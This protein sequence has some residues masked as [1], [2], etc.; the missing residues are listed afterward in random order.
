MSLDDDVSL[1]TGYGLGI[2]GTVKADSHIA[3]C[4]RA[5]P[6]LC[7]CHAPRVLCPL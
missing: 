1:V 5:V 4:A 6:M 7:P 2:Q 3:C